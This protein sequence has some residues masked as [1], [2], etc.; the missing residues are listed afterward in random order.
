MKRP[1]VAVAIAAAVAAVY[2]LRLDDI[3]GLYKDDAY[4]MVLARSLAQGSGYFLIS[5][6]ASPILPG[7]AP[8]FPLLLAPIFAAAPSYPDNLVWLKIPSIAAMIGVGLLTFCYLH[9]YRGISRGQAGAIAVLTSLTPG[10][11]FLATSTV[12]SECVFTFAMMGSAVALERAAQSDDSRQ[13]RGAIVVAALLTTAA[14]LIRESGLA[15][16]GGAVVFL[17]WKRGWRAA[18]GLTAVCALCYA[19]WAVYAASHSP[20]PAERAAHGGDVVRGYSAPFAD[21]V[22]AQGVRVAT[23]AVNILGRDL[24]AMIFPAGY[25]GAAESGFEAFVLTG[26]EGLNAGSMGLGPLPVAASSLV[27]LFVMV[28]AFALARRGIGVAEV[29]CAATVALLLMVA[30]EAV[31][32]YMLPLSPF[33]I[34]YFLIGVG[35]AAAWLRRG[36]EPVAFRITAACMLLL[37]V[38]EHGHYVWLAARGPVPPY[39]RDG[40]EV[41]LVA[42]YIK[43]HLPA[44][45]RIASTNPGLVYLLTGRKAVVYDHPRA[46]LE[47]WQ[48]MGVRYAAAFHRT[49]QPPQRLGYRVLFESPELR[50][51]LAELPPAR[52]TESASRP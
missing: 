7:F 14:W 19:P 41:R 46:N 4:Y 13:S 6:A 44:D 51:W 16:V 48:E 22:A 26:A 37:L 29:F 2:A 49:E 32:R 39:I 15:L 24:G 50:L 31:Y 28:G 18:A 27:A 43:A 20:T 35:S 33:V 10:L 1:W 40:R 38:G 45:A 17:F 36:A 23:N 21:S 11:V 5:S 3:A 25:R 12:M 34:A 8:G 9:R 52:L 42:N 47:R 30:R